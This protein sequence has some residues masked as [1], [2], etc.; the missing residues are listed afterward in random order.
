MYTASFFLETQRGSHIFSPLFSKQINKKEKDIAI[1][2][3]CNKWI[4]E[5]Y[6]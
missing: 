6:S 2:Y 5:E 4:P 3:R 1:V